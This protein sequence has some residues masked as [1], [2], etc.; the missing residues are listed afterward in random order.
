MDGN[1]TALDSIW[2]EDESETEGELQ[3]SLWLLVWNNLSAAETQHSAGFN[4]WS[5]LWTVHLQLISKTIANAPVKCS[6]GVG[7]RRRLV[8]VCSWQEW[9]RGVWVVEAGPVSC[10]NWINWEL[11]YIK[12]YELG[13]GVNL[14]AVNCGCLPKAMARRW[15]G[16]WV[17]ERQWRWC[18]SLGR[19]Y[20]AI[21]CSFKGIKRQKE[22]TVMNSLQWVNEC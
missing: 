2:C 6:S 17:E 13:F 8:G 18:P 15:D 20:P 10:N 11:N 16:G 14:I 3:E 9:R 5:I 1:G 4:T 7:D 19:N 22:Q 21:F 12:S